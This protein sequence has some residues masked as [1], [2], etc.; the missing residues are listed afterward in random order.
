[1]AKKF[2]RPNVTEEDE[3]YSK[4]V[5]C[6]SDT[7]F[8]D[9]AI[10]NTNDRDITQPYLDM[11]SNTY[12]MGIYNSILAGYKQVPYSEEI[13]QEVELKVMSERDAKKLGS[14]VYAL[15]HPMNVKIYKCVWI[16]SPVTHGKMDEGY[17]KN[18]KN[19]G[20]YKLVQPKKAKEI[21]NT[22]N[23]MRDLSD[24][25]YMVPSVMEFLKNQLSKQDTSNLK[26]CKDLTE[27]LFFK[28]SATCDD[29]LESYI[30]V[31]LIKNNRY[32]EDPAGN[33]RYPYIT[34]KYHYHRTRADQIKFHVKEVKK[35]NC[36]LVDSYFT[37]GKPTKNGK[38]IF[39]IKQYGVNFY[40]P[41]MFLEISVAERLYSDL[42]N[43]PLLTNDTLDLLENTFEHYVDNYDTKI[44]FGNAIPTVEIVESSV[45]SLKVNKPVEDVSLLINESIQDEEID[46]GDDVEEG[47]YIIED[48]VEEARGRAIRQSKGYS[49]IDESTIASVI[50][51]HNGSRCFGYYDH[52]IEYYL[53]VFISSGGT[54][55][56]NR[57]ISL[58]T[59]D[60]PRPLQL[61]ATINQNSDLFMTNTITH[62]L[63][64]FGT[65]AYKKYLYFTPTKSGTK[66]TD[67]V[68]PKE[69]YRTDE[70]YGIIDPITVKSEETCGLVAGVLPYK[71]NRSRFVFRTKGDK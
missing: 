1:M 56:K 39:V 2:K 14:T 51:G 63:D 55:K 32:Y 11:L 6:F 38:E 7:G 4:Y 28:K 26:E 71:F 35:H 69:R 36:V 5:N 52:L 46:L 53:R 41:F 44:E 12:S 58:E 8:I 47:E 27:D 68:N 64:V 23:K 57:A 3:L 67:S 60:I 33:K 54:S 66:A 29:I 62:P 9:D 43:N 18:K 50:L 31:P 34:E 10:F 30:I 65:V 16:K 42:I 21:M 59:Q 17:A 25:Y 70:E 22:I 20:V 48:P 61:L 24:E 40:N 49:T 45:K 19:S 15:T 37:T 13:I